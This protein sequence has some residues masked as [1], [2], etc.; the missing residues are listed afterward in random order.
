MLL[1]ADFFLSHRIFLWGATRRLCLTYNGG[2]VFSVTIDGERASGPTRSGG[3][4]GLANDA[5]PTDAAGF[6]RRA[7]AK[8]ARRD[9]AA[10]IADYDEAIKREPANAAFW[11]GRAQAHGRAGDTIKAR[12]DLDKAIA[13]TPDDPD[14]LVQ[15]GF[16]RAH[17]HDDAGALADADAAVKGMAE[18]SLD[19]V[20]ALALYDRLHRPDRAFALIDPVIALHRQD[21]N[22]GELLNSR[23]WSRALANID[24]EKALAD[25]NAAI[26]RDGPIPAYLDSRGMVRV[27][28]GD[29]AGAV[30]DY[31]AALA[32]MPKLAASLY[33]RGWARRASG[34]AQDGAADIAAATAIEPDVADRFTPFGFAP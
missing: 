31:D 3:D 14:L 15:R 28:Q 16:I 17:E 30:A 24:L 8:S 29:F 23:C 32:K 12:A 7:S 27:R 26:K 5:A 34:K 25:C 18:G 21:H 9:W 33:M 10:A 4:W 13:L 2:P 19:R 22:L 11:S 1:G 6:A 20:K